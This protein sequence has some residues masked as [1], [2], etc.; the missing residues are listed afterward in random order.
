[1]PL[2]PEN[3]NAYVGDGSLAS[4]ALLGP[5]YPGRPYVP[6]E[7]FKRPASWGKATKRVGGGID[8][9]D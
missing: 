4:E 1:M 8:G 7:L 2:T 3:A 6:V 5:V 9:R